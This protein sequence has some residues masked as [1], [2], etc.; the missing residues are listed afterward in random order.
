MMLAPMAGAS[1]PPFRRAA[2]AF[3]C[4]YSV[5]EIVAAEPLARARRDV[6]AR[7]AG[8]GLSPLVVQLAG[9]EPEWIAAG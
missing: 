5:S 8:Q 7:A 2:Q 4:R 6:L 9:R 1:D 3:G